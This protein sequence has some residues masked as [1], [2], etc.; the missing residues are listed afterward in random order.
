MFKI[1]TPGI[2]SKPIAIRP[3]TETELAADIRIAAL[4]SSLLAKQNDKH[5]KGKDAPRELPSKT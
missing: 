2:N 1:G 4:R 5:P 3:K